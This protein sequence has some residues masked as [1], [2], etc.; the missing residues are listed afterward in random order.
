VVLKTVLS[1]YFLFNSTEYLENPVLFA[2]IWVYLYT[3]YILLYALEKILN[4]D[5]LKLLNVIISTFFTHS[6]IFKFI[7][8]KEMLKCNVGRI[9]TKLSHCHSV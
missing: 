1:F 9:M 2:F 5:F 7:D 6:M 8:H 3:K 4:L